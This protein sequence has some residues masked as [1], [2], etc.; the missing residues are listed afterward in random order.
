MQAQRSAANRQAERVPARGRVVIHGER[1]GRATIL[2]ISATGLRFQLAGPYGPYL[3]GEQLDLELRFDGAR[4]G[5]WTMRGRVVSVDAGEIAVAVEAAPPDFEDWIQAQLLA[6]V[7]AADGADVLLVDSMPVRRAEMADSFRASGRRVSEVATPLD[8]I[9]RLGESRYH[10]RL[11][12][13]ADSVPFGVAEELRSYVR[14][15][16]PGIGLMRMMAASR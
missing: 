6:T 14:R 1:F 3:R 16:H 2:D 10:P 8:A 7:E 9:D 5:W 11:I 12:A 13:I 4:G 15:E